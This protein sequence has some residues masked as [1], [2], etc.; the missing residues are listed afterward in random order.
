RSM[1]GAMARQYVFA[2][3][4]RDARDRWFDEAFA[5]Y[6]G[7]RAVHEALENNDAATVRFFGQHVPIVIR[8]VE[9]SPNRADPRPKVRHFPEIDRSSAAGFAGTGADDR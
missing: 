3:V 7:T 2:A 9:W 5:L 4:A 6:T 1:I 8:P